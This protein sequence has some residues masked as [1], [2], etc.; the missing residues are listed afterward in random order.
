M[1]KI[2]V[3][4]DG[5][6]HTDR[7]VEEALLLSEALGAEVTVFTAVAEYVFSPRM[8]MHF[9]DE[10]WELINRH[11]KEEAEQIVARAAEPFEVKGIKVKQEI[12]MGHLSASDAICSKAQEGEF[13]LIVMGSRGLRGIKE[14]FL[15]SVSNKVAHMSSTSVLI[16]R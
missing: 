7:V 11:L 8:S 3:A 1:Y 12:A 16:V 2:L 10:N 14:V 6:E 5:S 15:G 9:T 4:V 13:N